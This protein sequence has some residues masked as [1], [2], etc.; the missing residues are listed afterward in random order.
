MRRV[1]RRDQKEADNRKEETL[2][3]A[4]EHRKEAWLHRA[5][6]IDERNAILAKYPRHP[7][8]SLSY[9]DLVAI[10]HDTIMQIPKDA[11]QVANDTSS[12]F[13]SQAALQDHP[14][15]KQSSSND[16]IAQHV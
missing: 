8:A 13:M 4:T 12:S 16:G 7:V 1:P 15:S 9:M 14:I 5:R 3:M 10:S 6:Q 11:I 2:R